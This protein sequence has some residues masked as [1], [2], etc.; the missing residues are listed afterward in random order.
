MQYNAELRKSYSLYTLMVLV[1]IVFVSL[2]YSVLM[3]PQH[4]IYTA[5]ILAIQAF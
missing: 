5:L 4:C 1:A 3:T 2:S